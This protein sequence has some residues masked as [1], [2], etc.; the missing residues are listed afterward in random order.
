MQCCEPMQSCPSFTVIDTRS[1]KSIIHAIIKITKTIPL[2]N[3]HPMPCLAKQTRRNKTE[4]QEKAKPNQTVKHKKTEKGPALH[5]AEC[6]PFRV[7]KRHITILTL[8]SPT[9]TPTTIRGQSEPDSCDLD[10]TATMS[11]A[12][13][14]SGAG[15]LEGS[16]RKGQSSGILSLVSNRPAL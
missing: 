4:L 10:V 15:F 5:E 7:T 3:G 11:I 16:M 8:A 1:V 14:T 13:R 12:K 9:L 2:T 6:L